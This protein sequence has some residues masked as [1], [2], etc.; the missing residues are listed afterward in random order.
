MNPVYSNISNDEFLK[1]KN[2]LFYSS[3]IT[4]YSYQ[5]IVKCGW[6]NTKYSYFEDLDHKKLFP[7]FDCTKISNKAIILSTGCYAPIHEGHIESLLQS[8]R[9]LNSKGYKIKNI[10]LSPCHD[11]YVSKKTNNNQYNIYER[12]EK[13]NSTLNLLPNQIKK[14]F[15]IDLYESVY[16]KCALNFSEILM[17]N[18]FL[19][20]QKFNKK[21]KIFYVFG[22]DNQEFARCFLSLPANIQNN[23][24]AICIERDNHPLIT[25]H[26]HPNI[27]Y[28]PKHH[29]SNL[30]SSNIRNSSKQTICSKKENIQKF[31]AIR[32][33]NTIALYKWI[34][35]YPQFK[36]QLISSYN[37]FHENLCF[38][39]SSFL[40]VNPI[41]INLYIQ[42]KLLEKII[43]KNPQINYFNL[44]IGTN[45]LYNQIP[46]NYGRLFHLNDYQHSPIKLTTRPEFQQ[47]TL[48]CFKNYIFIDD[49]IFTG[50]TLNNIKDILKP[51]NMLSSINLT[52]EYFNFINTPYDLKDII[53]SRDFLLGTYAGGLICQINNQITRVPYFSPFVNL[54]TRASIPY[55][56]INSFNKSLLKLNIDFFNTNQFLNIKDLNNSFLFSLYPNSTTIN[57]ILNNHLN[58]LKTF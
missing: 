14:L 6:I 54:N 13:I 46:L 52:K 26:I 18:Y 42:S 12:I 15:S 7:N 10:I 30:T 47:A 16:S 41:S 51:N 9:F 48:P 29:H 36:R 21:Y 25:K 34:E 27:F 22:S 24:F 37:S 53:D 57:Q 17:Y 58:W 38:L 56:L 40:A 44:D 5:E 32:N 28:L 49:D 20:Q 11:S 19:Y 55:H 2:D 8:K 4:N 35:T 45:Q 31:Y 3:M 39:I 43:K 50:G 33:D 1:I 23:F